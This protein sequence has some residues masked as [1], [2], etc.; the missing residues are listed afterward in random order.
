MVKVSHLVLTC[1]KDGRWKCIRLALN[2]VSTH[3]KETMVSCVWSLPT[4]SVN[5][6]LWTICIKKRKAEV[7]EMLYNESELQCMY[8][9]LECG[10]YWIFMRGN[11][12]FKIRTWGKL[13]CSVPSSFCLM[14]SKTCLLQQL[15]WSLRRPLSSW[16]TDLSHSSSF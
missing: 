16:Q 12:P 14:L 8:R 15:L 10:L 9:T 13:K 2:A 11:L 4:S 6:A 3:K 7:L 5:I 1:I